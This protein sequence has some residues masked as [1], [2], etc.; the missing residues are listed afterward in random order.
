MD[1]LTESAWMGACV[2]GIFVG[3]LMVPFIG[4]FLLNICSQ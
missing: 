3:F 2:V 1:Q 4:G